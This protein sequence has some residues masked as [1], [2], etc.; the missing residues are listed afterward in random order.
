[1]SKRAE[2]RE[3]R[4]RARR[5]KQMTLLFIV[6]GVALIFSAILIFPSFHNPVG[7]ANGP[8]SNIVVPTLPDRPMVKGT[9]MGD[10][11]APVRIEEYSDF[12]CPFCARFH[13]E[14]LGQIVDTYVATGKVY[15][16]FRQFAFIGPESFDAANASLCA[17]E[18]DLFWEYVDYLFANQT[19]ENVGAFSEPRLE[20]FAESLG[21]DM[22]AFRACM[23]EDRYAKQIQEDYLSGTEAQVTSTPSFVINGELVVGA[24]PFEEFQRIIEAKLAEAGN[25]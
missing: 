9:A 25:N 14:T 15:F 19:G 18:Q 11:N 8:S 20:A 22:Q 10:P 5:R 12:Q 16:V 2:I 21:L 4:R 7:N 3:R 23:R 17:A 24:L 13:H 6:V 1:M